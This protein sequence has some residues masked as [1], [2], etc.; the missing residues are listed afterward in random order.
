M[1][2]S[3][4]AKEEIRHRISVIDVVSEYVALKRSGKSHKGLCPFHTEKTPSF[5]VS[6]EFQS[7]HCFGCGEHGDVFSFLMKIENL[8]FSEALERLAKRA[9]IELERTQSHQTGQKERLSKLNS[10]AAAYYTGLLKQTPVAMEYL[11]SRGL[12]DQT[13]EEFKL[14]YAAPAWDGLLRFLTNKNVSLSD[15][16]QAGLIIRREGG[17]GYYDRFRHRIVFPILDIQERVIAFG[18]RAMGDEQP[19][20]LNSPETPL[21]RKTWSL[22]G[23]NLARKV[24]SDK[25]CAVVVEGYMDV[26]TA[27]QAGFSNTVATLGT[28]LTIEHI[29]VLSRYTNKVVLAYD[30]D[31]AGMT[32]ALRGA[33]MFSDTECDV[34]IA[35]LPSGDDPDSLLRKGRISEFEAAVAEALPI[36][37]YKLTVLREQHELSDPVARAAMLK[38]A[39]RILA[40]VPTN[41]ERE[42]HIKGLTRWH[43]NYESGT[44]RAEDHIRADVERLIQRRSASGGGKSAGESI[45]KPN[46]AL[47]KAEISVL[48]ALIRGEEGAVTIIDSLTPEDF[49]SEIS[50][51]SAQHVFEMFKEKQGIY[52][53]DL[54]EITDEN[55]GRFLSGIAVS[56]EG[57]PISGQALQDC[58]NLIKNSKQKRLRTSDVLAPYIKQGIIDA[59]DA[60]R[61]GT[62]EELEA[63]LRK[64]GKLPG[65][66]GQ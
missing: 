49:T 14:G 41:A 34:K 23:L 38:E 65:G 3:R 4:D 1:A 25:S 45:Q 2:D 12:A 13:I 47:G 11:R 63:F 35:R 9:G 8:T 59:S 54:L 46:T 56:D 26:I 62:I 21:F 17:E 48:R 50:H 22:Y 10:L 61:E 51:A 16:A 58:I 5:T 40:E 29:S 7:W 36:V 64:S 19:K 15:A 43:P 33:A 57:P 6:E 24:I 32:A 42:R 55:V 52:L 18:G 28:A 53:P 60:P 27:H 39:V 20:Y 44:T 30:A 37:D 66:D 31:S